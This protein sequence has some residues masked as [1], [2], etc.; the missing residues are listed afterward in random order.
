MLSLHIILLRC[1]S[2]V[3]TEMFRNTATSLHL[4]PEAKSCS[5]SRS[6][7]VNWDNGDTLVA[8]GSAEFRFEW[9]PG[10]SDTR[11]AKIQLSRCRVSTAVVRSSVRSDLEIHPRTPA[12]EQT[13]TTFSDSS[14]V[15]IKILCTG[16][17]FR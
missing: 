7:G 5:T 10:L 4:L 16:L 12:P 17:S 14:S 3:F 8:L 6:R 13:R 1:V 9:P 11:R 15:R 2:P